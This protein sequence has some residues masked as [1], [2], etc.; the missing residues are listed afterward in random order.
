MTTTTAPPTSSSA[1]SDRDPALHRR[2]VWYPRVLLAV[3]A[4]AFVVIIASGDGSTT[5]GGRVGGDYPA[6]YAAGTLV[7]EGRLDDLYD[8]ASQ[9]AAQAELM[10]TEDGY[11]G[12]A[13]TPHVAA[14]YAPLASLPYRA[15]YVVHTAL[16]VGALVLALQ[17]IRPMVRLVDEWF[18]ASLLVTLA[19]YPVFMAVGGGQNTAITILCLAGVWRGLADDREMAAGVAVTLLMFRPQYALPV[20]GLL[21]LG[22]HTRAVATAAV[23][24]G[25]LWV[26]NAALYGVDWVT[27]WMAEVEPF[28]DAT[29]VANARNAISVLGFGRAVLGVDAPLALALGGVAAIVVAGV[30]SFVWWRGAFDLDGRMA[31]TATGLV[32]LSPHALFYD[33]G[34]MLIT[35]LVLVDRDGRRWPLVAA[36]WAAALLHTTRHTFGA[37]PFALVA[38]AVFVATLVMLRRDQVRVL[39]TQD[40]CRLR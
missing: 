1:T 12:F 11:L 17:L 22:R 35:L 21:L 40:S 15:S 39:P 6:F 27:R 37:T 20:L 24:A 28:L 4:A 5:A 32:L 36:V 10:G 9:S 33:A 31:L 16:M 7:A 19:S 8:T 34:V 13:Y 14:A 3:L 29:A 38:V 18:A 26:V 30:L 25:V 2:L 23:G